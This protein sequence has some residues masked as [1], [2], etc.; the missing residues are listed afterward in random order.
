[1]IWV[2]S[3][4]FNYIYWDL[5]EVSV[6]TLTNIPQ[7]TT[8]TDRNWELLYTFFEEDREYVAYEDI[9]P[10]LIMAFLSAE[11][12]QYWDHDGIDKRWLIRAVVN[13]VNRKFFDS[14]L[15]LQGA[16]T[17]SQQLIKNTYLTSERTF[18]R[19]IQEIII[20]RKVYKLL[21]K[22][23]KEEFPEYDKSKI[24]LLVKK[25]ILELYLNIIFLGNNSYGV[26]SASQHY[27]NKEIQDLTLLESSII[28]WLPQ[29][30]SIYNPYVYRGNM[31]WDRQI[32]DGKEIYYIQ[33]DGENSELFLS[34]IERNIKIMFDQWDLLLEDTEWISKLWS[35]TFTNNDITYTYSYTPWRK[36]YVLWSMYQEWYIHKEEIITAFL[37]GIDIWFSTTTYSIQAP[38]FVFFVKDFLLHNPVLESLQLSLNDL[39]QGWYVIRTSLDLEKQ[40][41]LE[42]AAKETKSDLLSKWGSSR[43]LLHVDSKRWEIISY[44]WSLDYYDSEIDWQYDLIHA[45]RQQGSTLKPFVYAKLM[46]NFPITTSS[47]ISDWYMQTTRWHTPRNADGLFGWLVSM[48]YALN[49]SRNLTAIRAYL[50]S[51][52]ESLMKWFL[53]SLGLT[54]IKDEIDYWYT[55][56]LWSAEESIY[57]LS[58]AYLQLSSPHDLVPT[59]NP[60]LSITWPQWENIYT[61]NITKKERVI[62]KWIAYEL[63]NVLKK[64]DNVSNFWRNTLVYNN[65]DGPYAI[66]TWTSDIKRE[67]QVL[68]KDGYVVIYTP[69]DTIVSRAWN[70]DSK[71]L[72]NNVLWSQ[73]NKPFIQKYFDNLGDDGI[74]T[75]E[76][77]RPNDL[78][79]QW[80][81]NKTKYTI[82]P[83]E[84]QQ[85]LRK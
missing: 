28:A 62:P 39:L 69:H 46:E 18:K 35:G 25:K 55:L 40:K 80:V 70:V 68:P 19:K 7:K 49:N 1:M 76:F 65:V 51:W 30:P 47:Q 66:K 14:E 64:R 67:N 71:P 58:Q 37:E 84:I 4:S 8:I 43:A 41:A 56:A 24:D 48:W 50:A 42:N 12:R 34:Q 6:S 38:H 21:E 3:F 13:N 85:I 82:L 63:W 83:K 20:T 44:L 59:I 57:H 72:K 15:S 77:D 11:D 81:Y 45:R 52:W 33:N 23:Y 22:N 36:D 16:S 26:S 5:P 78:T 74:R 2:F 17:I 10:H 31:M 61:N 29:A 60:I 54:Y 53:Q 9:P 32:S 79:P 75:G 27:F 73:V